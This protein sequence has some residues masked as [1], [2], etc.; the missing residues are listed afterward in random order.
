M[1]QANDTLVSVRAPVGDL[2]RASETC[3]IGRGVA[4]VRGDSHPSTVYYALR[5]SEDTWAPFQQEG[6][7]FG[8]I[9]KSDLSKARLPWPVAPR[10]DDLESVLGLLDE[11]IQSATTENM[12]LG[13]L[14]D[15]LLPELVSGRTRLAEM[16]AG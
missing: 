11:K 5:A 4:A 13:A 3:C 1:A 2:N 16:K 7:V 8:S 12:R 10:V 15:T 6:T 9:N 14:R